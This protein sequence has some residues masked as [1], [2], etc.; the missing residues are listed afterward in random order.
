[1]RHKYRKKRSSWPRSRQNQVVKL[2]LFNLG[3]ELVFVFVV[4]EHVV[5]VVES[6]AERVAEGRFSLD[7]LLDFRNDVLEEKFVAG[8][9]Y[10]VLVVFHVVAAFHHLEQVR[11]AG[12]FRRKVAGNRH[13]ALFDVVLLHA[14]DEAVNRRN[15]VD[16]VVMDCEF[17]FRGGDTGASSK[18]R[19]NECDGCPNDGFFHVL[20]LLF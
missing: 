15:V 6:S 2:E 4:G 11:L 19:C 18:E 1:M 9:C 3:V 10:V 17:G 5:A 14:D 13:I 12:V 20:I 7:F 8:G 16:C